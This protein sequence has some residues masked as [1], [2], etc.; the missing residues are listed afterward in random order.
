VYNSLKKYNEI[1][2][3]NISEL[4]SFMTICTS[5]GDCQCFGETC[6]LYLRENV[7]KRELKV[8]PKH[9][10][11]ITKQQV[12]RTKTTPILVFVTTKPCSLAVVVAKTITILDTIYH[13]LFYLKHDVPETGFCHRHQVEPTKVGPIDRASLCYQTPATTLNRFIKPTAETNNES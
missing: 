13:A 3:L 1:L 8:S 4:P 2:N 6:S 10:Q 11:P 12:V 7:F 9:R 5:V